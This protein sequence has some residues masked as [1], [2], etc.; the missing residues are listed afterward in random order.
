M[1]EARW[2]LFKKLPHSQSECNKCNNKLIKQAFKHYSR[3]QAQFA[4]IGTNGVEKSN[5]GNR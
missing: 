2:E 4:K 3:G 1:I 5:I